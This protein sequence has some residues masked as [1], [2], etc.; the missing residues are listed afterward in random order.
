MKYK[1]T[2]AGVLDRKARCHGYSLDAHII[3]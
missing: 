3:L 2:L 1:N